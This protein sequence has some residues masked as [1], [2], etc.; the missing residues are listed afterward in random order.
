MRIQCFCSSAVFVSNLHFF[1]KKGHFVFVERRFRI[2][3]ARQQSETL[4]RWAAQKVF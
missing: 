3:V 1:L 4:E 2:S